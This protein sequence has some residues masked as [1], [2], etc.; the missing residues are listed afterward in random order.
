[1]NASSYK[2]Q[3]QYF[4]FLN[5]SEEMI[6]SVAFANL[7]SFCQIFR[8][9]EISGQILF[10]LIGLTEDKSL[11]KKYKE[12]VLITLFS[13]T[14]FDYQP[15]NE[16]L[17]K[18]RDK[19]TSSALIQ[20]DQA[21]MSKIK[22]ET[23]QSV[24]T[25]D[26]FHPERRVGFN[27]EPKDYQAKDWRSDNQIIL[28][29]SEAPLA[30]TERDRPQGGEHP[31]LNMA[32]REKHTTIELTRS[33][34][35][36]I[37]NDGEAKKEELHEPAKEI[38]EQEIEETI[39]LKITWLSQFKE[40]LKVTMNVDRHITNYI[41]DLNR[42]YSKKLSISQ[43]LQMIKIIEML[44]VTKENLMEEANFADLVFNNPMSDPINVVRM[45]CLEMLVRLKSQIGI[46]IFESCILD[47]FLVFAK[48]S[49][50]WHKQQMFCYFITV[51]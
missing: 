32:D 30:K 31:K 45:E 48:D 13:F 44:I 33:K 15:I 47:R 43:R 23:P 49:N 6:R 21:E 29:K 18:F 25:T 50:S 28:G 14:N 12:K 4:G 24:P 42:L 36:I 41:N 35:K 16:E 9:E 51:N 27:L 22:I 26:K 5:D 17:T 20:I 46:K 3:E 11:Q 40:N 1:M 8:V 2:I 7:D 10:K 37:D 34:I 19:I 38:S 39:D